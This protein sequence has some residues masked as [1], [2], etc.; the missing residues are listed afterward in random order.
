MTA[1]KIALIAFGAALAIG[2]LQTQ[3]SARPLGDVGVQQADAF[4][5]KLAR[6]NSSEEPALRCEPRARCRVALK[7]QPLPPGEHDPW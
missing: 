6:S 4:A 2:G 1:H 5:S 3:A 7:S